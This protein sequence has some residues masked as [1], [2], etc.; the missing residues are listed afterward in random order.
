MKGEKRPDLLSALCILTFAGSTVTFAGYFLAAVLFEQVSE[1]I[2]KYS[3]WHSTEQISQVYFT[4]LMAL[5]AIS[6]TGAIRMWKLHRD[7]FYLYVF[8]QVVIL[9]LPVMWIGGSA[10]SVSNLI[11][12]A[13]FIT[14]YALNWR[15]L[16]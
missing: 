13:V 14:G 9:F 7:G 10:F 8:A 6:L 3:S 1:L 2:I 12:T 15:W 11:F 4:A 16:N 5:S